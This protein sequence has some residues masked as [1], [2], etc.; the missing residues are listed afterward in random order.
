MTRAELR[1]LIEAVVC[2]WDGV[3]ALPDV[4]GIDEHDKAVRALLQA[5]CRHVDDSGATL[6]GEWRVFGKPQL[7]KMCGRCEKEFR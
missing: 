5:V 6:V 2:T 3:G 1:L 4:S 7:Q